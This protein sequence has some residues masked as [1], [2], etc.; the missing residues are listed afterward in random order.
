MCCWSCFCSGGTNKDAWNSD[1]GLDEH[2]LGESKGYT[3]LN[4]PTTHRSVIEYRS[5][6]VFIR[7][8]NLRIQAEAGFRYCTHRLYA[9]ERF[10]TTLYS[11]WTTH[12][13]TNRLPNCG[14]RFSVR[15]SIHQKDCPPPWT[16]GSVQQLHGF[17]FQP[18]TSPAL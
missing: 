16:T 13:S 10:S 14:T 5:S 2:S 1:Y 18:R 4:M 7:S 15:H 12:L 8:S 3:V 17:G 9:S 6:T 11:R